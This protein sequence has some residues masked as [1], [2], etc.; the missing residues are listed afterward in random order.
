VADKQK[1]TDLAE[2][3]AWTLLEAGVGLEAV[4][5]LDLPAWVAVPIAGALAAVKSKFAQ[6]FGNGTG[7]TV[8]VSQEGV[9][10]PNTP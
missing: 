3:T 2:R 9:F 8:P 10:I 5:L 1:W 6:K 4:A 7:A